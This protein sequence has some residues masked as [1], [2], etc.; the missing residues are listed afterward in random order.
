MNKANEQN[1]KESFFKKSPHLNFLSKLRVEILEDATLDLREKQEK[2]ESAILTYWSE[3]DVFYFEASFKVK[4]FVKESAMKKYCQTIEKILD[5]DSLAM[6]APVV[7]I[8][9]KLYLEKEVSNLGITTFL[10][11]LLRQHLLIVRTI[12]KIE[13]VVTTE[14]EEALR[15]ITG[16]I[17]IFLEE[18]KFI[19][20]IRSFEEG[21]IV[22]HVKL[23]AEAQ[24]HFS[25]NPDIHLCYEN[26]PMIYYP[27]SWGFTR[28]DSKYGW[29]S[30]GGYLSRTLSLVKEQTNQN[31]GTL[32]TK[33]FLRVLNESQSM[34]LKISSLQSFQDFMNLTENYLEKKLLN[35]KKAKEQRKHFSEVLAL[36]EAKL[37]QDYILYYPRQID[38]RGRIYPLTQFGLSPTQNQLSRSLLSSTVLYEVGEKEFYYLGVSIASLMGQKGSYEKRHSWFAE[39]KSNLL[40]KISYDRFETEFGLG[41]KNIYSVIRQL[42]EYQR[43]ESLPKES[44]FTDLLVEIDA[45]SSGMQFISMFV[46]DEAGMKLTG[47]LSEDSVSLYD[48][49]A[50]AC[51]EK[52]SEYSFFFNREALKSIIMT[53]PYGSTL[54]RHKALLMEYFEEYSDVNFLFLKEKLLK[55]SFWEEKER[56]FIEEAEISKTFHFSLNK[57]VSAHIDKVVGIIDNV[58][59]EKIPF[60]TH[61]LTYLQ[62][63]DKDLALK[64]LAYEV[65]TPFV[66]YQ[67]DYY[68]TKS[69]RFYF[70][71]YLK[72]ESKALPKRK[73]MSVYDIDKTKTD[74]K[75]R[76][77]AICANL[78]QGL[79]D[80]FAMH[81]ILENSINRT[82]GLFSIHDSVLLTLKDIEEVEKIVKEAYQEVYNYVRDNE[83]FKEIETSTTRYEINSRRIFKF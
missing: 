75:K 79:G 73:S 68:V 3:L 77:N 47:V 5:K 21:E 80:A 27:S 13:A 41:E 53:L 36:R 20:Q 24:E 61:L 17:L 25:M 50:Q 60:F 83:Y 29:A 4:N 67:N 66:R 28:K 37:L 52:N 78:V 58:M 33:E 8:L 49:I 30:G 10:F 72:N 64:K 45:S 57:L 6:Y 74:R 55:L 43:L 2:I 42:L 32:L 59:Q 81:L 56:E 48:Y 51:L 38:G 54:Y 46:N 44:R 62:E 40:D 7:Q 34:G 23:T 35:L 65:R 71:V 16:Q 82:L 18:E 1:F 19:E 26:L 14:E 15:S 9:H 63:K 12:K 39:Q 69:K 76:K 70:L 31:F 22:M 11:E